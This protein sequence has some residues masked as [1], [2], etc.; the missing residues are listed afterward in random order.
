[1]LG[2]ILIV[3]AFVQIISAVKLPVCCPLGYQLVDRNKGSFG[4]SKFECELEKGPVTP[5][6]EEIYG[7]NIYYSNKSEIPKCDHPL[8]LVNLADLDTNKLSPKSC[9][10][11]Y[12]GQFQAVDCPSGSQYQ[13][14]EVNIVKK[15][16]PFGKVYDYLKK[17][18]VESDDLNTKDRFSKYFQSPTIFEY[19]N[20]LECPADKVIV[21]YYSEFNNFT[22]RGNEFYLSNDVY[23]FKNVRFERGT[24]CVENVILNQS[25][26]VNDKKIVDHSYVDSDNVS[27]LSEL[28][29]EMFVV[30]SCNDPKVC[31]DIPCIRRCCGD[32]EEYVVANN[33]RQCVPS[34]MDLNVMFH[35]FMKQSGSFESVIPKGISYFL[36]LDFYFYTKFMLMDETGV[37]FF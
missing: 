11:K 24:F 5:Q 2:N 25:N 33:S 10:T 36:E 31:E 15:C 35:S 3:C 32:N 28:P 30:R 9:V 16:C 7:F 37:F 12:M 17:R 23:K 26:I 1:M 14:S 13:F 4:P 22:F 21:E 19:F 27:L 18:C 29:S 34:E 6:V 8:L 20:N